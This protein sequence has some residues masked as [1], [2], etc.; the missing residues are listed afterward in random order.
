MPIWVLERARVA[1]PEGIVRRVGDYG[2]CLLDLGHDLIH[3]S[4]ARDSMAQR[5]FRGASRAKRNV[6]FMGERYG[7]KW[8]ASSHVE[9]QRRRR[10]HAHTPRPQSPSSADRVPPIKPQRLFE[11]VNTKRNDRDPW[12]H[13]FSVVSPRK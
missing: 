4:L 7:A 2:S 10:H 1:T 6:G 11:I 12:L 5:E 3:F 13:R 9:D 8:R